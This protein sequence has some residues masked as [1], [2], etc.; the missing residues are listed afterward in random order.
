MDKYKITWKAGYI[1]K[2]K[3]A[4]F[5]YSN[6]LTQVLRYISDPTQILHWMSNMIVW[7]I[8]LGV[9]KG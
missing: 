3:G 4:L 5:T 6:Y 9:S 7:V 2:C 1:A 8:S